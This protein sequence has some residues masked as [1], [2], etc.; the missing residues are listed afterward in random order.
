MTVEVEGKKQSIAANTEVRYSWRRKDRER[1]LIVDSMLIKAD[2][3]GTEAMNTFMNR[4]KFINIQQGRTNESASEN[5]PDRLKKMLQESFGTPLCTLQVDEQ[6][7]EVKR[8]V[9]AGEGAKD[10][11]D[12][13]MVANA[14]LF[15]PPFLR[16]VN[17][18]SADAE[19]S[20]GNGGYAKGKLSYKK[21]AGGQSRQTCKVSGTLTNTNERFKP[22]H[23]CGEL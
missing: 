7:R 8:N 21:Q 20:M 9:I 4:A 14:L 3:N 17:E 23:N 16:G 19:V 13:G 18:W 22:R 2:R 1:S 10:L 5:A 15:H 11:M 6:G 12:N